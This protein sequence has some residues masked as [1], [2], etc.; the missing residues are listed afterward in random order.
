MTWR[1]ESTCSS[2]VKQI[3]DSQRRD[4]SVELRDVLHHHQQSGKGGVY[5]VCSAHPHVIAA[6][7][8]QAMDDGSVPHVQRLRPLLRLIG[9]QRCWTNARISKDVASH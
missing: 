8:R 7:I 1:R 5:A 3:Q 2:T 6:A 9:K 4:P